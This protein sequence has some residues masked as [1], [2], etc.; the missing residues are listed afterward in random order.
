MRFRTALVVF[1]VVSAVDGLIAI[2]APGAFLHAIWPARQLAGADLFVSGWGA[3]LLA[4]S[5]LAWTNRNT[6]DPFVCRSISQSLFAYFG[7]AS[8]VW[9]T[10]ALSIGWTVLSAA[11]FIGLAAFATCRLIGLS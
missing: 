2:L 5:G 8:A 4:M 6:Q 3:C 1:A 10:D 9:F 11:T 7:I